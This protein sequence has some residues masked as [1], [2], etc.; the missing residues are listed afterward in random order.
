MSNNKKFTLSLLILGI[1]LVIAGSVLGYQDY[2][3]NKNDPASQNIESREKCIIV[4]QEAEYDVTDFRK[5]HGGGDVFECGQDMTKS[6][7]GAHKGYLPMIEKFKV[8]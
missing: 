8:N 1:F 2:Q 4:I 5:K 3:Y 6:F 7:Q